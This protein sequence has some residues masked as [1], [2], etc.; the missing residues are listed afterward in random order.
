MLSVSGEVDDVDA[1]LLR[2]PREG[3][4]LLG[5]VAPGA[6]EIDENM[7]AELLELLDVPAEHIGFGLLRPGQDAD[8]I[9]DRIGL[10]ADR[11]ERALN[12]PH[13]RKFQDVLRAAEN[14]VQLLRASPQYRDRA[15][16]GVRLGIVEKAEFHIVVPGRF[17]EPVVVAPGTPGRKTIRSG[18]RLRAPCS[19]KG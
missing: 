8:R 4:V 9:D 3:R 5:R 12:I 2:K 1:H 15:A 18:S 13:G 7:V 14:I 17:D 6:R 19:R 11:R 10:R 16:A